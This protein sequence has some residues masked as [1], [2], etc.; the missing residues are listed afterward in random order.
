MTTPAPLTAT[1]DTLIP[2]ASLTLVPSGLIPPDAPPPAVVD[3]AI[4][5][6]VRR[7]KG[8]SGNA[9][10]KGDAPTTGNV[11]TLDFLPAEVEM[12]S[13][14]R[15]EVRAIGR[16]M[17][18]GSLLAAFRGDTSG[19]VRAIVAGCAARE[20][21]MTGKTDAAECFRL[22]LRALLDSDTFATMPDAAAWADEVADG[23]VSIVTAIKG[24]E[25]DN[26]DAA[27]MDAL[28]GINSLRVMIGQRM[29]A[30]KGE[31]EPPVRKITMAN[32]KVLQSTGKCNVT[33][34]KGK[35]LY[36]LTV[37]GFKK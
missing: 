33:D 30:P 23:D 17:K 20:Y 10:R 26:A 8:A 6:N 24:A 22:T 14:L 11:V 13:S 1:P 5:R 21:T 16:D 35:V 9:T 36:V 2:P 25:E 4:A 3:A 29:S 37:D 32:L 34:A 18:R 15:G 28:R 31:T 27:T 19:K 7:G 12:L